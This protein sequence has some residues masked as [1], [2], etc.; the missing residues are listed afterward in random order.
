M[1]NVPRASRTAGFTL[2]EVGVAM[3][4]AALFGL[5]AFATNQRLLIGLRSQRETAG[6]VMM[7]QERMEALRSLRFSQITDSTYIGSNIIKGKTTSEAP[8]GNLIETITI[9]AYP[10]D[11][12]SSN[13]WV[14]DSTHPT[15][16]QT[17]SNTT[18]GYPNGGTQWLEKASITI[19]WTGANGRSRTQNLST[20]IDGNL[21]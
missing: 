3:A 7:L 15:G 12:S 2:V 6:A 19:T 20:V 11:A 14:R 4:V 16:Y 13:Q 1:N 10:V 17:S 9:S 5:A 8:L 18:L 21:G